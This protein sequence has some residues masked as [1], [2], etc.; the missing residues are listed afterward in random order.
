MDGKINNVLRSSGE[1]FN[2]YALPLSKKYLSTLLT[3]TDDQ[4]D[5]FEV[6]T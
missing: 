4:G 2:K 5:H 6:T 1:T 3:S